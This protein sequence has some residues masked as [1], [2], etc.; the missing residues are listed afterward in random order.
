[1]TATITIDVDAERDLVRTRLAGFLTSDDAQNYRRMRND[2]QRRLRCKPGEQI[3]LI[4]LT[5]LDI[6]SQEVVAAFRQI[7]A[8]SPYVARKIAV[9]VPPSLVRTQLLR[10]AGTRIGRLF[11]DAAAAE[12][13]LLSDDRGQTLRA[14]AIPS[15]AAA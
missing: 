10:A 9:V 3:G 13:W 4:D 8:G 2:A 15:A 12:T 6:Q 11:T 14:G 1:M 7:L 5:A